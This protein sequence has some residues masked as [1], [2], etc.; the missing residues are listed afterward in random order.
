M[1]QEPH[2]FPC[3]VY[4]ED[5]D[6]GGIVYYANYLKF[7]ERARTEMLR[8]RGVSQE[9]LRHEAGVLFAIRRCEVD[10][11]ASARLDDMLTVESR[12][13]AVGGAS[14]EFEQ[15]ILCGDRVLAK[16]ASRVV[17][18]DAGGRPTRLPAA[19]RRE[20]FELVQPSG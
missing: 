14:I 17:C 13:A 7:A 11:L 12:I 6:A 9:R 3:R 2:R 20:F 19:L 1:R 5:T 10:Y 4:W 16:L 15:A 18:I 8:G